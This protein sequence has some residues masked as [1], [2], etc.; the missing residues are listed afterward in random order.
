MIHIGDGLFS[1]KYPHCIS[2]A[3][4]ISMCQ[5]LRT[6]SIKVNLNSK[7]EDLL[8]A[9]FKTQYKTQVAFKRNNKK[10]NWRFTSLLHLR[11]LGVMNLQ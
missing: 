9:I 2:V 11:K 6:L 4:E 7:S 3:L 8:F 1:K 5:N 10:N